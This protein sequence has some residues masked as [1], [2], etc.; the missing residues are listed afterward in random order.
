[1]IVRAL[2]AGLTVLA[3]SA[4][5][6]GSHTPSTTTTAAATA[7]WS[8]GLR[9]WGHGMV[10]SIDGL[11]DLFGHAT[12]VQG[13]ESGDSKTSARLRSY[14]GV[15]RACSSRVRSLGPAPS[16]LQLARREGLHACVRL[17]AAAELIRVGIANL[18][19]GRGMDVLNQASDPLTDGQD[20]I[21]RAL[22]DLKPQ[23]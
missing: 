3:L 8:A 4:C 18:A 5:G 16:T 1:L 17:E 19:A 15:L 20:G 22:L 11:S 23:P 7:H 9:A 10:Q 14:I 6:G 13:L 12:T 21:R 2:A